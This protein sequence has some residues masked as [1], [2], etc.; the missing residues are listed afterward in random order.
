MSPHLPSITPYAALRYGGA[1]SSLICMMTHC[2]GPL[3]TCYRDETCL[4]ILKCMMACGNTTNPG[5]FLEC[6][7]GKP[8]SMK[9][10]EVTDCIFGHGCSP[11]MPDDGKCLVDFDTD[12]L[13]N[14]TKME[15]IEG[16]WWVN[17]GLNPHYDVL[18]CL[19]NNYHRVN[20]SEDSWVTDDAWIDPLSPNTTKWVTVSPAVRMNDTQPGVY[21]HI[22]D[23]LS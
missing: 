21:W 9:F 2:F 23:W 22:Y 18:K 10:A 12:G 15:D 5:C 13:K 17:K 1:I 16:V 4:A 7:L 11:P 14:M 3:L 19:H 8:K 20:G 6:E